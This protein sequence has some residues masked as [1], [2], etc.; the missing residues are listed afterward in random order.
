[1]PWKIPGVPTA[2]VAAVSPVSTP[3]PGRLAADQPH[4]GVAR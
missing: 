4:L 2:I 1:M 3:A